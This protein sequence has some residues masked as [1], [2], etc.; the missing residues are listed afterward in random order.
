MTHDKDFIGQLESY[1]DEYEGATPLPESVRDAVRAQLPKTKQ[2]GPL[3][4]PLRYLSMSSLPAAARYGLAAAVILAVAVLGAAYF[5]GGQGVGG[6]SA[7]SAT[8]APTATPAP[9]PQG[10]ELDA[11]SY[12]ARYEPA[13]IVFTVPDGWTAVSGLA[14]GTEMGDPPREAY[15]A[16]STVQ[17]VY[18]D[19]CHWRDALPSPGTGP[20]V[21]DLAN[22][23]AVQPTRSGSDPVEAEIDGYRGKK[24]SVSVPDDVDFGD[25]DGGEF[26]SWTQVEGGSRFHQGPGQV[27]EVW[28]LDV[29]GERVVIAM[30]Y[31]PPIS[32]EE[33]AELQ[34][35]VDSL[36]IEP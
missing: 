4:G 21:D 29:E 18:A 7:P 30:T 6:P 24:V 25:C 2:S 34:G 8:P 35:V 3:H 23:L 1:L 26:R 10:G 28:I 22:A 12:V 19:P 13:R 36:Q 27:D 16:L 9:L 15:V 5:A 20:T 32:A 31:F 17:D 14:V 11:G 33:R